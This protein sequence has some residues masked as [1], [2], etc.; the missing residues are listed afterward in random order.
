MS[1]APGVAVPAPM[2]V[3]TAGTPTPEADRIANRILDIRPGIL[4]VLTI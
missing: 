2:A 3:F 1:P 4:V